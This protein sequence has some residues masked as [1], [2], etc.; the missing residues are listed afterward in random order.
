MS[1]SHPPL[2]LTAV[3][4]K[5][6]RAKLESR[7]AYLILLPFFAYIAL[8]NLVPLVYGRDLG[9]TEFN[10]LGGSPKW[11]GLKNYE[12][13]FSVP[14]YGLLLLRQIWMGMLAL[15]CNTII[16]FLLALALNVQSRVK[17]IFRTAVYVPNVAAVSA[18]TAVFVALLNPLA[19]QGINKILVSMGGEAVTWSYSQFWMVFWIIVY[20]VWQ[21]VGPAVIIWLGGL[22]GIDPSLYEAAKVDGANFRQQ[23]LYIT[24]PG[25]RFI[26]MYI[27]LTG[28]IGAMQM[29]DVIMFISKGNPFGRTDVLMYRIYRDGFVNFNLGMAGAES[30]IL[31][32]V[33]VVFALGYLWLQQRRDD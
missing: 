5:Y 16:S 3:K 7:R 6:T 11:V 26:S 23:V 22:Q 19:N 17:G 29:F 1:I 33:T 25:L 4:R 27:L 31:G 18:T 30:L 2:N 14:E 20:F 21:R 24:L 9:F 10:A 12:T 13:F 32:L 28:I 8:W 15:I